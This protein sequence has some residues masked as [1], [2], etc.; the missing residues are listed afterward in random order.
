MGVSFE[1]RK[2]AVVIRFQKPLKVLSSAVLNGGFH[3]AL[4]IINYHVPK[5]F[6]HLNPER[7]L[8]KAVARLGFDAGDVV[9]LMTAVETRNAAAATNHSE[10][11]KVTAVASAGL[12]NPATAGDSTPS[13]PSY[14]GTIN[15]ILIIDGS[16]TDSCMVSVVKTATE[17]KTVVLRTL[18][19]RSLFSEDVASGT[20]SDSIAVTCTGRGK[21]INYAG[22][23]SKLGEL[24][25]KATVK[26]LKEAVARQSR[27]KS[28]RNLTGK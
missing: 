12:S 5:S 20:T 11:L 1:V 13:K 19:V 28:S 18:G 16:L 22:S 8:E 14:L 26:A 4:A 17:A 6:S 27:L 25:G 10:G 9:G 21:R 3:R 15:L 23:A 7:F 24:V 2:E